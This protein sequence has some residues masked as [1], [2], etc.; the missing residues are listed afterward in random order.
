MRHLAAGQ[1]ET[2]YAL[3]Y[4]RAVRF[5]HLMTGSR[6]A[7]D[8]AQEAFLRAVRRWDPKS[9]PEAFWRWLQTTMLRLHLNRLRRAAAEARAFARRGPDPEVQGEPPDHEL[10]DALRSLSPRQRAAVVLRYYEDLPEAE[11]ADR[12]GCRPGTVK[13]LLHQA[14]QRVRLIVE[15]ESPNP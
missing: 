15:E 1:F 14:R 3:H 2:L 12:L 4:A 11:I 6:E 7:E 8:L 9:P 5:A 13:A 10:L